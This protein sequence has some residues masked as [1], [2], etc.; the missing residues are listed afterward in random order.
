MRSQ[1]LRAQEGPATVLYMDLVNQITVANIACHLPLDNP[2][3]VL[4][5]RPH[6]GLRLRIAVDRY[7]A[8]PWDFH[9]LLRL[10]HDCN[11]KQYQD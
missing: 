3:A 9:W 10:G 8:Y 4:D 11:S 5:G 7:D 1:S 6:Y 2:R